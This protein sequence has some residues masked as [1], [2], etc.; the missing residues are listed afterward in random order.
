MNQFVILVIEVT[1]Q[2]VATIV[3][4]SSCVDYSVSVRCNELM[5][6]VHDDVSD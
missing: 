2:F 5:V 3:F 4:V 1:L 6:C